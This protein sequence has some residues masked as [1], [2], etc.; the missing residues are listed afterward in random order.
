MDTKTKYRELEAEIAK[1]LSVN[2]DTIE[3][4]NSMRR[5]LDQ[6]QTRMELIRM[7]D[8]IEQQL[9]MKAAEEERLKSGE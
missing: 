1:L 4:F 3:D 6:L 7:A 8:F 9:K 5:K 2:Y